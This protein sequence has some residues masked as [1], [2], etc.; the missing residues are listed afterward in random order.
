MEKDFLNY[1]DFVSLFSNKNNEKDCETYITKLYSTLMKPKTDSV[2][3]QE[4]KELFEA[5]EDMLEMFRKIVFI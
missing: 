5:N 1:E 3:K 4:L 2:K